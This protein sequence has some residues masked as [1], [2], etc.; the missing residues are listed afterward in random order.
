MYNAELKNVKKEIR[1]IRAGKDV[2]YEKGFV[3][4]RAKEDYQLLGGMKRGDRE[5]MEKNQAE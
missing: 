2:Q 3:R 4:R 1:A 5:D